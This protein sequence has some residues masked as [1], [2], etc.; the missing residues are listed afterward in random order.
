MS[1]RK[2]AD[3]LR[4]EIVDYHN[5]HQANAL[6]T[7]LNS[8]ALHPMGGGKALAESVRRELPERLAALPHAFSI[9]A[10]QDD[11]AIGLANCFDGFSTFSA[12]PLINIHDLI[13]AEE[14]RGQGVA[15]Q[16]LGKIEAIGRAKGC[17]KITLEVLSNNASAQTAYRKFGF[18][19]YELAPEAGQALFWQKPL[20]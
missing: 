1:Q 3:P 9:L 8:Y 11:Q 18:Q 6:V 15:Q 14:F 7:L 2:P 20:I 19:G 5:P 13:V 12:Q 4:L 16:L 10:Y 17:G